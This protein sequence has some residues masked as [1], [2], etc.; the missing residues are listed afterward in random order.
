MNQAEKIT[1]ALRTRTAG[2]N[3]VPCCFIA[4]H[5]DL[6]ALKTKLGRQPHSLAAAVL[7][8]FGVRVSIAAS[9]WLAS[10]HPSIVFIIPAFLNHLSPSHLPTFSHTDSPTHPFPLPSPVLPACPVKPGSLPGC[11]AGV[12]PACPVKPVWQLFHRGGSISFS[13]TH[14]PRSLSHTTSQS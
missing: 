13:T 4:G 8:Q 1:P 11:F 7:E 9:P 12:P 6:F 2:K 10:Q 14:S 3:H 5:I